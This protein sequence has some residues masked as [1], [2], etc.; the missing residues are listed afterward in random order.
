MDHV[1]TQAEETVTIYLTNAAAVES[2]EHVVAYIH[3][4]DSVLT[5]VSVPV[6]PLI[7]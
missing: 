5:K 3:A 7:T 1:I 2:S 6:D 4:T